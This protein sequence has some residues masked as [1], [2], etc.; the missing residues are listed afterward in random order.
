LF[1]S[2]LLLAFSPV[3]RLSEPG[4][5]EHAVSVTR[6]NRFESKP[7]MAANLH[8]FLRSI[9]PQIEQSAGCKSCR[10]LHNRELENEFVIIEVWDS[11]SAHQASV[12]NISPEKFG[13]VMS[14]LAGP[15]SGAYYLE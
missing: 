12:K 6:I 5:K 4:R 10:L 3:T 2:I 8:A 9:M 11:V 13:A 15:P 7:G 1:I 14:L